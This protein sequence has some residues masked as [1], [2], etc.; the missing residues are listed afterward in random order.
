MENII[1]KLQNDHKNFVKVL[2]FLERQYQLLED[3]DRSD[4]S[5]TL[6]AIKY[7]KEYPDYIHHPL[8]NVVFKY[9]LEHYEGAH[10][11][12]IDLLREHEEL[13]V[14]TNKLIEMLQG[15]L[16]DVPQKREELCAD[17]NNYISILKEHL[18]EEEAHIFPIINSKLGENDWKN[19]DT[20][21]AYVEDPM[22]GEKVEKAY[23][24]L[25]QHIVV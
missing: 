10:E 7:M 12:I 8:E 14:L 15:I 6:D 5:S 11:K 22:F 13:P 17:L 4:L 2:R 23:R 3:C 24:G 18:N 1:N 9:Y 21:L 19:I 20:E 16:S 25:V